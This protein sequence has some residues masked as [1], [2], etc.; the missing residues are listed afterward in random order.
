M[1]HTLYQWV[2]DPFPLF[3]SRYGFDKVEECLEEQEKMY[4]IN[5]SMEFINNYIKI[6]L[7]CLI[8]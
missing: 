1:S 2:S 8:V 6:L 3:T 7:V 4:L 5:I